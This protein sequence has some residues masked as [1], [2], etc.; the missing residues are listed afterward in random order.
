[1]VLGLSPQVKSMPMSI[2]KKKNDSDAVPCTCHGVGPDKDT[3]MP[4]PYTPTPNTFTE[5]CVEISA[6]K[7]KGE[8]WISA[9]KPDEPETEQAEKP[10]KKSECVPNCTVLVVTAK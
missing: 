4:T 6:M 1:M 7:W 5:N 9:S 2:E 3:S 10:K 8:N